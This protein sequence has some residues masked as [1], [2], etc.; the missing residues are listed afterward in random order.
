MSVKVQE[1][2]IIRITAPAVVYQKS[3]D[4]SHTHT[5]LEQVC[6]GEQLLSCKKVPT[7]PWE[8]L[9][10]STGSFINNVMSSKQWIKIFH[11]TLCSAI[12]LLHQISEI[13]LTV[14]VQ[15]IALV[16]TKNW[17]HCQYKTRVRN[18]VSRRDW[19]WR[20]PS[21]WLIFRWWQ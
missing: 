17:K 20:W 15:V 2:L 10:L 16:G 5:P 19:P 9:S 21:F 12:L 4:Q 8:H 18:I 6:L 3:Q 1:L 7:K 14:A 13:L 11:F